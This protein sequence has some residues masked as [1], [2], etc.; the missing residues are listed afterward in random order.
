MSEAV[1]S[2]YLDPSSLVYQ[3]ESILESDPLIDEVGFVHPS[4]FASMSDTSHANNSDM[5]M[6]FWSKDHKLGIS[7]E[8]IHPLYI[9]AKNAFMSSLQQYNMLIPLHSKKVDNI[10]ATSSPLIGLENE[11][12]KHKTVKDEG[13]DDVLPMMTVVWVEA[14]N[15]DY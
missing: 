10:S 4:Q 8:S 5:D 6:S 3:L 14:T 13:I 15:L 1:P 9:A 7:T 12:M 2:S 11:L